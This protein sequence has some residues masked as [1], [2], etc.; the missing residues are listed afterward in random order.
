MGITERGLAA[1]DLRPA[2][3][4]LRLVQAF[5]NT[6]DFIKRTER[7][8]AP[9]ALADWLTREGLLDR[10]AELTRADLERTIGVREALRALLRANNGVPVDAKAAARLDRSGHGAL[11]RVRV[12]ADGETRLEP[13]ADGLEAAIGG[14]L[15]IFATARC[16]GEWPR[17][18][19]CIAGA[20]QAAFWDFSPNRAAQWCAMRRCGNRVKSETYRRRQKL[21]NSRTRRR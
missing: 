12:D 19:A 21:R 7:F 10:G 18:K 6:A 1:A 16:E 5:V 20:C 9:P 2:P 4:E 15:A 17:L 13:A 8:T 11:L 3:G 14:L